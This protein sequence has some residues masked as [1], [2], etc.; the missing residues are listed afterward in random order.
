MTLIFPLISRFG[1]TCPPYR[2]PVTDAKQT[3]A[4]TVPYQTHLGE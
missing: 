2:R 4:D 3:I 1:A